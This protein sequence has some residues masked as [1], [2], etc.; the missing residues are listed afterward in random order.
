MLV[1]SLKRHKMIW[2]KETQKD[3]E[4]KLSTENIILGGQKFRK[5]LVKEGFQER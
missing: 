4:E 5:L 3:L 2:C 1:F